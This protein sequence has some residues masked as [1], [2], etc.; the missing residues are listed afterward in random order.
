[1]TVV[2]VPVLFS[3]LTRVEVLNLGIQLQFVDRRDGGDSEKDAYG[4]QCTISTG[5]SVPCSKRYNSVL[6][7]DS[8]EIK[9]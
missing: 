5:R 6:I 9:L 1:M 2:R 7:S 8:T 4:S 3:I